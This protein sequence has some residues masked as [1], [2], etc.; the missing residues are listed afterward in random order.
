MSQTAGLI[1][2]SGY[3]SN[4]AFVQDLRKRGEDAGYVPFVASDF[5]EDVVQHFGI[6]GMHWGRKKEQPPAADNI[7]RQITATTQAGHAIRNKVG[8]ETTRVLLQRYGGDAL[9]LSGKATRA[10]FSQRTARRVVQGSNITS[11]LLGS[12]V[13]GAGKLAFRGGKAYLKTAIAIGKLGFKAR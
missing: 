4:D 9:V 12:A 7:P 5:E 3:S 8:A 13:K 11:K 10:L 6:P 1:V 2:P